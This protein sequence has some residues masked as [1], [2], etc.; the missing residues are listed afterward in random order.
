[1]TQNR[2]ILLNIVA[3]Y[4]RSVYA[5]VL[6]LFTTRWAL[7]ALG[8]VDFGL[9][10]VVGGLT[11]FIAF[12]NGLLASAIGR[13][14]AVEIGRLDVAGDKSVALEDCR[15]WFSIATFIHVV[16]PI[17]LIVIG[18][19]IGEWMVRR[20]LT[21]PPDR[22]EDCVWVFRFVC[23]TCFLAMISVPVNA[24]YIAKQYIAELTLYSFVA[25][26][27]NAVFVYYMVVH[28]GVWLPWYAGWSCLLTLLPQLII[29]VRAWKQ[30][31]ECRFRLRYCWDP[32]RFRQILGYA[33]WTVVGGVASL[34][35]TQGVAILINKFFGP[36]VNAAMSVANQVNGKAMTLSA[37]IQGAMTPVIS[38]AVGVGDMR[39]VRTLAF[40]FCKVSMVVSLLFL[41]PLALELPLVIR[42]WLHRPPEYAIGLC[43]I[44]LA[45]SF[46]DKN[47]LGHGIAI[48]SYGRLKGYQT[49][50]G[51][52]NLLTI[53]LAWTLCALGCNVY[54]VGGAMFVTWMLL[55]YG[56]LYFAKRLLGMEIGYWFRQIMIPVL[57]VTVLSVATGLLPILMLP[58]SLLRLALTTAFSVL[59]L[60]PS[61]CFF[62]LDAEERKF[63]TLKIGKVLGNG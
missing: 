13:F 14:Y 10:G 27:A 45:I 54:G 42:L 34:L 58:P 57:T 55:V 18:Y 20:F 23:S 6:G 47:T 24:M 40:R 1:M 2:R 3:T 22:V 41:I 46:V 8:Q 7:E 43:W 11:A 5:L 25:T 36:S 52:F 30:F 16:V 37:S 29:T 21:I 32:H 50:L 19:P 12:F 35:R 15:R 4:G 59:V 31:P 61:A 33:G 49:V 51:T 56:R 63:L 28:P 9:Y 17:G 48:M 26:T 53:P 62:V 44:M 38:A 60:V 39:R